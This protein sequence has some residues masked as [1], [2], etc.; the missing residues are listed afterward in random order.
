MLGKKFKKMLD[1]NMYYSKGL[2]K[3]AENSENLNDDA[4]L[5]MLQNLMKEYEL[6]SDN[7]MKKL[8]FENELFKKQRKYKELGERTELVAKIKQTK[9]EIKK[10]KKLNKKI[11]R[12]FK[13]KLKIELDN[14][15][16]LKNKEF[17]EFI[18]QKEQSEQF[19]ED[20]KIIEVN[21]QQQEADENNEQ[22]CE[23]EEYSSE[24]MKSEEP[25]N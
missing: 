4:L 2:S 16:L 7:L 6:E 8:K 11:Y 3:W 23:S 9:L 13:K 25:S 18:K 22:Q 14:E 17:L 12:L 19:D 21:Q 5:K 1:L 24:E 10:R 20:N 15:F